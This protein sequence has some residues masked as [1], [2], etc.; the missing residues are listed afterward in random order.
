MLCPKIDRILPGLLPT[1]LLVACLAVSRALA[2][3]TEEIPKGEIVETVRCDADRGQ[4]Y[5][6]YLPTNYDPART[7]PILYCF[8]PAARGR[9]PVERFQAAAEKYGFIVVGSNTSRNGP[10][11]ENIVAI[12]ALLKDSLARC[13]V[14]RRR[15]Y[16]AGFSGGARAA[17]QLGIAGLVRGV[18]ACGGGF[19]QGDTPAS[20]SFAFFGTTGTDDLNYHELR[21]IDRDLDR[22]GSPHRV[23]VFTGGHEWLPAALATEAIE[24]LEIHAMR[25]GLRPKDENLIQ[26]SLRASLAPAQALPLPEA[27]LQIKSLP[28]DFRGLAD[29]TEIEKRAK[30]LAKTPEVRDWRKREELLEKRRTEMTDQLFSLAEDNDFTRLRTTVTAWQKLADAPEP[31]DDRRLMR[32]VLGGASATAFELARAGLAQK[33]YGSAIIWLEMSVVLRPDLASQTYFTLARAHA[34]NGSKKKAVAAL[35]QAARAGFK[36][37]TRVEQEAAFSGLRRDPAFLELL[38]AMQPAPAPATNR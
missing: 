4:T 38:R 23:V 28:V 35:Q 12:N 27:W 37:A 17:C 29:V 22:L 8:D 16:A 21:Q 20:V 15:L 9:I 25:T 18:I 10:W 5:A 2:A 32:Q 24:W 13:A 34:L 7:W 14:D 6:L 11:S 36:D 19:P 1:A 30:D 33:D 31:S 26:T 3:P